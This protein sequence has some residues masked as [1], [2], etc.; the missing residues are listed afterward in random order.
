[1]AEWIAFETRDRSMN[2]N[3]KG[4]RF[5]GTI[6]LSF[7]ATAIGMAMIVL[8][9]LFDVR[10]APA[11]NKLLIEQLARSHI[12]L[13]ED[14]RRDIKEIRDDVKA[15]RQQMYDDARRPGLER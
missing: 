9:W 8:I 7:I 2:G 5:D 1:M 12:E 14:Y 6:T 13:R 4:L 11:T 15:I 10:D 3:G